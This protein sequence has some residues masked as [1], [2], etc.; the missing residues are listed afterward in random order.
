MGLIRVALLLLLAACARPEFPPCLASA[1]GEAAWVVDHGW[2]TEVGIPAEQATGPL[3]A[4]RDVF[5][6]AA[7]LAFGFGKRTFF[8]AK[9]STIS[10]YV[11]GPFPGPGAVQVVGLAGPPAAAYRTPVITLR[12]PP[13]GAERLSA[14]LWGSIE[15]ALGGGPRL[16]AD[17]LFPGS[18]F[19]AARREYSLA[20]TCNTWALDALATA[21]LPVTPDASL[22]S[23]TMRAVAGISGACRAAP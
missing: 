16:I 20:Y 19:Y 8:I 13:G 5:P 3:A 4:F 9:A 14:F 15:P 10:E 21:G 7:V 17:G 2:H 18:A 22:A 1:G 12:L 23:G 6:G 11:L